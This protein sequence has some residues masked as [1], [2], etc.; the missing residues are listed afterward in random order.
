MQVRFGRS[1]I[2]ISGVNKFLNKPPDLSLA[3]N[4]SG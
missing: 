4:P 2:T 3:A 1:L